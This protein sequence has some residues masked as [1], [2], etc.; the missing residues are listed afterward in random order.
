MMIKNKF[1]RL[2]WVLL[3]ITPLSTYAAPEQEMLLGSWEGTDSEGVLGGFTFYQDGS[4]LMVV[5]GEKFGDKGSPIKMKW[6]LD[7]NVEPMH[8]DITYMEAET[9]T[10]M[11]TA[12]MIVRFIADD[13]LQLRR[14]DDNGKRAAAFVEKD[15]DY[16]V[17]MLKTE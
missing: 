1:F 3:L 7:A 12:E 17:T 2:L 13:K 8:L 4:L 5:D 15:D 6:K 10:E 14:P 11:D 16:Q 9:K